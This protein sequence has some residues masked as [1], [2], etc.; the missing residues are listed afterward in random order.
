M[1]TFDSPIE[2]CA[3]CGE[4]VLIDQTQRECASEHGCGDRKCP[5]HEFFEGT[6][7]DDGRRAGTRAAPGRSTT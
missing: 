3:V 2:R 5:L 4:V 1:V 7:F 6:S